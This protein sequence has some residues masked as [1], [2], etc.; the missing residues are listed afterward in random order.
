MVPS[1]K[2]GRLRR[3]RSIGSKPAETVAAQALLLQLL[4][5]HQ[6]Q[7]Q[8]TAVVAALYLSGASVVE[9]AILGRLPASREDAIRRTLGTVSSS[10]KTF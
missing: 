6:I 10:K 7:A 4:L 1:P 8:L 2:D 5:K 9:T 3:G